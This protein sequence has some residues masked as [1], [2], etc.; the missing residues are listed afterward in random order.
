[1][2]QTEN[3]QTPISP[4]NNLQNPHFATKKLL[5]G[6]VLILVLA[7]V[8]VLGINYKT[9]EVKF[10]PSS[11]EEPMILPEKTIVYDNVNEEEA[12]YLVKSNYPE[13][14]N[15]E[16]SEGAFGSSSDIKTKKEDT[17]WKITFNQ[18]SGDCTAGCLN[19]QYWYFTV[20]NLKTVVKVGEYKRVFDSKTNSY[21]ETGVPIWNFLDSI[22]S[23]VVDSYTEETISL[24]G[25]IKKLNPSTQAEYSYELVLE[26]PYYDQLQASGYPYINSVPVLSTGTEIE[27][28]RYNN[29]K[30]EAQ[31]TMAWGYSESRYLQVG[32]IKEL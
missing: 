17:L 23:N 26:Q 19:N 22:K 29:K 25:V 9:N 21:V 11:W 12:I 7:T 3:I 2:E 28:G 32:N 31:G 16:I 15:I 6:I 27:L 18:G 13:V 14:K 20:D 10:N 5:I 4:V 8:F 24:V 30:V 1:M